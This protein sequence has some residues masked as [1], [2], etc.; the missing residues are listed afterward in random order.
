MEQS[1]VGTVIRNV[2]YGE[3]VCVG[4]SKKIVV[5]KVMV[6]AMCRC[7]VAVCRNMLCLVVLLCAERL[8][9]R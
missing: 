2:A 9:S 1:G 8:H 5:V 4:K 7:Y 3:V 6:L